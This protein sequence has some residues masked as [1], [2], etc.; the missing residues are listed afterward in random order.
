MNEYKNNAEPKI[1]DR[2]KFKSDSTKGVYI[3]KSVYGGRMGNKISVV[4]ENDQDQWDREYYYYC[5]VKA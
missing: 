5:F 1:G 4:P 2:V 3:V